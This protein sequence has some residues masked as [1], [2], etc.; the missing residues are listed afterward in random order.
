MKKPANIKKS[1]IFIEYKSMGMRHFPLPG[2]WIGHAAN[3]FYLI[4]PILVIDYIKL[5]VEF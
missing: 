5:P 1:T 3:F 2:T 4:S